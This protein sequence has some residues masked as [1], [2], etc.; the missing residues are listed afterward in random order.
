MG[1]T[2][3]FGFRSF[4]NIVRD[5]RNAIP[6]DSE[7]TWV[8]GTAV[9]V[10]AANQGKVAKPDAGTDPVAPSPAAGVLVYEHIQYKGDD[11]YLVNPAD[12][13]T[14][15]V[16]EFVQIVRGNGTKIWLKNTEDKPLYDRRNVPGRT[17]VAAA[18]VLG[19][20]LTPDADGFWEVGDAANGWLWIEQV[21]ADTGLFECRLTF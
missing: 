9:V 3:N 8:I 4:E 2:R 16:G 6:L 1:Y 13:D 21:D 18:A 10:D 20:Y 12:K 17:M 5:G 7:A 14:V 15:P 11:P 19:D